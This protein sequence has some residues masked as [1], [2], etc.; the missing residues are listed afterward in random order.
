VIGVFLSM[1]KQS[2]FKRMLLAC[3][4]AVC[5]PAAAL[6]IYA[7][8]LPPINLDL[9]AERSPVVLD[10]DG[11]LLRA[12]T[13]EGGRWRLP[14]TSDDVDPRYLE[15]L[16]AFEDKRF[17]QHVGV[18][19]LAVFRSTALA[20]RHG[21]IISGGS[22]LT[23]QV[24]R[25]VEPRSERN[26][27]AKLRQAMQAVQ[28]ERRL[29]KSEILGL[30]LSLAPF[31][32]NI[33]GVRA[34]SFAYFGKEPKRLS[35]AEAALLV[36]LPQAPELRR[37][38]RALTSAIRARSRVLDRAVAA[39]IITAIESEN[40]RTETLP[41][42]RQSLPVI[43]A[44]ATEWAI[45]DRPS[46][47]VQRL[48]IDAKIQVQ[49]EQLAKER[50]SAIGPEVSA[51]I[52]VVDHATGAIRASVGGVDYFSKTRAGA[53]DLTKALRSP[54]SALKPL[55]Y[56]LAF[57]NGIAHPETMLEDRPQRYGLYAPEN[58]DLTFQGMVTARKALQ[59]SLNVPAVDL[60]SALGPQRFLSRLR[61][62]GA[63][64]ALPKD[65]SVPGLAV[66]LGGLGISL[67]DMTRI[68]AAL[69]NGGESLPLSLSLEQT[70]KDMTHPAPRLQA[71]RLVDETP[72]WY[73]SDI[74]RAA[75]PPNHALANRIAFKTG[76]SYG[77]RDAWA[78]G[79]DRRHTIGVWV[80]RADNGAVQGLVG[81]VVAAPI[82]FD[83]FARLGTDPSPFPQ[84]AGALIADS[85]RL[86]PPL[87]HLR[88]DT[89]KTLRALAQVPLRL[90]FPPSGA[91]IDLAASTSDRTSSL[92]LK[93]SGGSPPFLWLVNG[94][95][96]GE[97]RNSRSVEWRPDGVGFAEISVLDGTGATETVSIRLQ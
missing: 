94:Q 45:A 52:L 63:H 46:E 31:G 18:D 35:T 29:S 6:S 59:L 8:S 27:S 73:I 1:Q 23:M 32:G 21:R 83:A 72:A 7:L 4:L 55:I 96:L 43:A 22:T 95:P 42:L 56:A 87:R 13:T 75:P 84:P 97:A 17:A 57:E 25:L 53:L 16:L 65:G 81:R 80:G 91:K 30:Y 34:A 92:Q 60:L 40:A 12:F 54:G 68:Y 28:L 86:P 61:E 14:V 93:A 48:T 2:M 62:A 15:M 79:Y 9:T 82:L 58:F 36:A 50:A 11:R 89:P 70:A 5:M 66:G 78:M 74:L 85:A 41:A 76:T 47:R 24:A 39:G 71:P 88:T 38:D 10:R 64:V 90:A 3:G 33:E 37:P 26:L 77:Y 19:P 44:H 69:A 20:L 49:M 51:A 67:Q